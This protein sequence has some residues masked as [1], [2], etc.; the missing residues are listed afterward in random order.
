MLAVECAEC[1]VDG[2]VRVVS[3]WCVP[4]EFV[5]APKAV[6]AVRV[7]CHR[8]HVCCL[9]DDDAR[10]HSALL[11]EISEALEELFVGV[12]MVAFIHDRLCFCEDVCLDD[13][14]VGVVAPYP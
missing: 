14:L 3:C 13:G 12:S 10:K 6:E 8:R 1:P 9:V 11:E 4:D 7:G 5:G 2:E